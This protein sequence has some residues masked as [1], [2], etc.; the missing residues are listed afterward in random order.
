MQTSAGASNLAGNWLLAG[1]LPGAPFQTVT[2]TELSVTFS[3]VGDQIVGLGQ[4]LVGCAP[5]GATGLSPAGDGGGFVA[6]GTVAADGSFVA[7]STGT[8][9]DG[10]ALPIVSISGTV[11]STAG[12]SWRRA[13]A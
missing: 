12:R 4:F 13:P 9:T 10:V 11:P 6:S 1:T 8:T 5:A 2:G 3:T 7:Q